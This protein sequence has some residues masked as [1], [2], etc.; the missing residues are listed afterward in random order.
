MFEI[1]EGQWSAFKR[2]P[3]KECLKTSGFVAGV[4]STRVA[5]AGAIRDINLINVLACCVVGCYAW[6]FKLFYFNSRSSKCVFIVSCLEAVIK[7]RVDRLVGTPDRVIIGIIRVRVCLTWIRPNHEFN[8]FVWLFSWLCWI[9]LFSVVGL[10]ES[11]RA[12]APLPQ[13]SGLCSRLH[14]YKL[15]L[16]E[17][18]IIMMM[19][20]IGRW[21]SSSYHDSQWSHHCTSGRGVRFIIIILQI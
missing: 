13:C 21:S 14:L 7:S 17:R 12:T 18:M 20:I 16:P 5:V 9:F 8:V 19:V 10:V 3:S 4:P 1:K 2:N 15:R 6:N 11:Y